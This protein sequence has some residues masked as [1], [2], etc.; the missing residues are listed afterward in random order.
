[1]SRF[2]LYAGMGQAEYVI[3]LQS[4]FL[5][6]YNT[7]IVA[8]VISEAEYDGAAAGLNPVIEFEGNPHVVMTHLLS[9]VPAAALNKSIADYSSEGERFTRALDL[10]FQGY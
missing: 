6:R 2:Q 3:D 9:A 5:N 7:R 1:M 4:D 10:L 8:P